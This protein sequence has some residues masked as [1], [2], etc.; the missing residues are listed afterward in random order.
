MQDYVSM[1][2]AASILGVHPNT[3]GNMVRRGDLAVYGVGTNRRVRL[4]A[5][6][7]LDQLKE[8]QR[9]A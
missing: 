3:I 1:R 8:V 7:D 2:D 4:V 5:V 6:R 9:V